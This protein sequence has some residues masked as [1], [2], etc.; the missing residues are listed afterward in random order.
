[1]TSKIPRNKRSLQT[2]RER[3]ERRA[4]ACVRCDIENIGRSSAAP[5]G[6]GSGCLAELQ[7]QLQPRIEP[8]LAGTIRRR[9]CTGVATGRENQVSGQA[10]RHDEP[11]GRNIGLGR[12]QGIRVIDLATTIAVARIAFVES[13]RRIPIRRG[14]AQRQ[15]DWYP[16]QS[17][18]SGRLGNSRRTGEPYRQQRDPGQG[19]RGVHGLRF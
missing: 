1:M 5:S 3:H 2:G 17:A 18:H 8:T 12:R 10:C 15:S 11:G 14:Q 4:V 9:T 6:L 19:N 7:L 13:E 16:D